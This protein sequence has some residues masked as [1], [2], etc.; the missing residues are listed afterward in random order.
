M[1]IEL[2]TTPGFCGRVGEAFGCKM[3]FRQSALKYSAC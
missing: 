2:F 1:T 3:A